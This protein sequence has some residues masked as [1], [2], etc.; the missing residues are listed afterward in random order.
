MS[1]I[2]VSNLSKSYKIPLKDPGLKGAFKSLFWPRSSLVHAIQDINFAI[3]AGEIVAYLG[4]NG[5]G[6]STTIKLLTGILTPSAGR[7]EVLGIEP[8]EKRIENA[9]NIGVVFG[10]RSQLRWDLPVIES[11]ELHRRLYGLSNVLYRQQMELFASILGLDDLLTKNVRSLSLGQ[12]MLC[13]LALSLLHKPPIVYLDEPTIGLDIV[14]KDRIRDFFVYMN[15]EHGVSIILTSLYALS[16]IGMSFHHAFTNS[17]IYM[18]QYIREGTLDQLLCLP[19]NTLFYMVARRYTPLGLGNLIIGVFYLVVAGQ[20]AEVQWDVFKVGLVIVFVLAGNLIWF[21]IML[22]FG[23][24]SFWVARTNALCNL[25]IGLYELTR[26]PLSIYGPYLK[27]FL[28]FIV[29]YAFVAYYP[30]LYLLGKSEADGHWGAFSPLVA[31]LLFA[32]TYQFWKLGI[33]SY[34]GTGS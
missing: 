12:K 15:R 34:Q 32:A 31:I 13:D 11:F 26:Y 28:T 6:K 16:I 20:L 21:S 5:A 2:T 17:V 19:V 14:V 33:R 25:V 18:E 22:F 27:G 9:R 7:I 29:P 1:I 3:E 23:A 24:M 30:A 4:P 10:Q 8:Y